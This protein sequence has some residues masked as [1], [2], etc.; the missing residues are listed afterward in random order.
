MASVTAS[1]LLINR[2]DV[3]LDEIPLLNAQCLSDGLA[4]SNS[5]IIYDTG[6]GPHGTIDA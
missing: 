3:Y 5:A 6:G 2:A 1:Y 4:D